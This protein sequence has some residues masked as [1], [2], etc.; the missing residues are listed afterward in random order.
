M[1]ITMRR[2]T[3]LFLFTLTLFLFLSGCPNPDVIGSDT[4]AG[5][6]LPTFGTVQFRVNFDEFEK[7]Y[8]E[9]VVRFDGVMTLWLKVEEGKVVEG[10]STYV[11][12]GKFLVMPYDDHGYPNPEKAEH[13]ADDGEMYDF[14]ADTELDDGT[15]WF[16]GDGGL[17]Y[18]LKDGSSEL[19][20]YTRLKEEIGPLHCLTGYVYF[21]TST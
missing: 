13:L 21:G 17:I 18:S 16:Y 11:L 6:A 19:Y 7:E 4:L 1:E 12:D 14:V 10:A 9:G 5:S 15:L 8:R 2:L 20:V 3:T